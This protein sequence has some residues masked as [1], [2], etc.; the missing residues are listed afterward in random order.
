MMSKNQKKSK[1]QNVQDQNQKPL[2][3]MLAEGSGRSVQ[4][5]EHLLERLKSE[6][7]N[8]DGSAWTFAELAYQAKTEYRMKN[9]QIAEAVGYSEPRVGEFINTY[10]LFKDSAFKGQAKFD[11]ANTARKV[12]R[13][14][15]ANGKAAS[16]A[17][18][19]LAEIVK[20]GATARQTRKTLAS[21]IRKKNQADVDA[22]ASAVLA[23]SPWI[24]EVCFNIDC[25]KMLDRIPDGSL[26]LV[27]FDPPYIGYERLGVGTY[28]TAHDDISGIE[29]DAH[30]LGREA[31]LGLYCNF[32]R[33]IGTKLKKNRCVAA[34]LSATTTSDLP[35][36]LEI[37]KAIDE[38]GLRIAHELHWLKNRIPPKSFERPFSTQTETIWILCR[39][40][41]LTVDCFDHDAPK[42]SYLEEGFSVRS[43]VI[44]FKTVTGKYLADKRAGRPTEKI[45]HSFEKPCELSMYLTEKLSLPGELVWDACACH[46][47]LAIGATRVG[48]KVIVTESHA[49]RFAECVR[50]IHRELA[51]AQD[52]K[53][54]SEIEAKPLAEPIDQ[55]DD[56]NGLA[57]AA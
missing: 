25:L 9:K 20:T 4:E 50:R 42:P 45:V 38:G 39:K 32:F 11:L 16:T 18:T 21:Q 41:D 17:E 44:C 5:V 15:D 57:K 48:R 31:A 24:N 12:W 30:S 47:N 19:V 7:Q 1:K 54:N 29:I 36:M 52:N 28:T 34:Y 8:V 43:N 56:L 2:T 33:R 3:V 14:F 49:D 22:E 46:G 53:P 40:G 23:S 10:A 27:H 26:G 37:L 13:N 6:A 51:A 35:G 55:S